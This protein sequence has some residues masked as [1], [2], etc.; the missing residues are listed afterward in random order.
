MTTVK[1]AGK[2]GGSVKSEARAQ[3]AKTNAKKP[4]GKWVTAVSFDYVGK[5][6]AV[7]SGVFMKRGNLGMDATV[8]A[9]HESWEAKTWP[10]S[11]ILDISTVSERFVL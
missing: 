2:K 3:A 10:I 11:E 7:H 4:R 5:D 8:D 1:Q 9:I 6:G